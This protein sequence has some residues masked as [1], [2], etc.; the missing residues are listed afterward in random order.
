VAELEDMGLDYFRSRYF[1]GTFLASGLSV[2]GG[3][4]AFGLIAPILNVINEDLGPSP[5][6][7]WISY[8]Y[9]AS[10]AVCFAVVGRVS[11]LFGRRYF[12]A[13]AS[14][15]ALLGN[16]VCATAT[17][18]DV[19]IGGN[20]LMGVASSAQTSYCYVMGELVPVKY[21][22]LT[23]SVLYLFALPS[24]FG[25]AIS[26]SFLERN[27][28]HGWRYAYYLQIGINAVS[29]VLW[30]AFYFPPRFH[31]KHG[32]DSRRL[33]IKR[34]DYIGTFLFA[35]GLVVFLFGLSCGGTVYEWKSGPTIAMIIVGFM[36][37]VAFVAWELYSGAWEPLVPLQLFKR[38]DWVATIVAVGFAASIYYAAAVIWPQQ[39]NSLYGMTSLKDVGF[40]A[41]L[42]GV[43]Q[44]AGEIVGGILAVPLGYHRYQLVILFTLGG[45]FLGC[46]YFTARLCGWLL[47]KGPPSW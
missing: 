17:R 30:L 15:L 14:L 2:T 18:I 19:L 24:V 41:S 10:L 21:R 44:M 39:V 36:T 23:T 13:G 46:E 20:V 22:Y 26:Y 25:P 29:A 34:F 35:G 42:P 9:N 43:G 31:M 33:W 4:C 7:V 27:P 38:L 32:R 11:D 16:I 47:T 1:I 28:R 8:V 45:I 3:L 6:Y 40:M 37:L 12:F 5:S